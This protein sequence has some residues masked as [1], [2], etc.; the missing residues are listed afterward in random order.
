MGTV[1]VYVMWLWLIALLMCTLKWLSSI[2][3]QCHKGFYLKPKAA[4]NYIEI[5]SVIDTNI[6]GFELPKHLKV[7]LFSVSVCA[8]VWEGGGGAF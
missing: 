7:P 8:C 4:I 1:S 5:S 2:E 3:I 6:M